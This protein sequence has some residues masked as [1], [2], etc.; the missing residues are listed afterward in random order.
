MSMLTMNDLVANIIGLPTVFGKDAITNEVAGVPHT[1]WYTSGLIGAG[2][3]PTGALNGAIFTGPSVVGQIGMPAAVT[4]EFSY[5]ERLSAVHA[6]GMGT[7]WLVDRLW[8]NVPVVTTTGAQAITAPTFPARDASAST[9]GA[10][11]FLA[12]EIS[13][14]TGN[15]GAITNTTAAYTNSAGVAARTATLAS[16]PATTLQGTWLPFALQAGDVGVRTPTSVTL[17]TSY[18]SGACHLVA[19]RLI[20]ALAMPTASVGAVSA[21]PENGLPKIWDASCLQLVYW[22]T[23]TVVGS[24]FGDITYAQG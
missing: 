12:L 10:G 7:L 21:F 8:G 17:G 14:T 19:Y 18:V 6:G 2:V 22:P 16:V 23:G 5:L 13:Q 4:S 20:A 11:V 1:P 3:A 24:V 15:A 9:N